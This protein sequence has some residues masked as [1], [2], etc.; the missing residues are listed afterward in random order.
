MVL[1]NV[2]YSDSMMEVK[3]QPY[4]LEDQLITES[5]LMMIIPVVE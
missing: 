5:F 4:H 1:N 2:M 3:T